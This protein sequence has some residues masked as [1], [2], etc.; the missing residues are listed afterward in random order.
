MEGAGLWHPPG[1]RENGTLSLG[2]ASFLTQCFLLSD[3]LGLLG[4][5]RQS[6]GPCEAPGATAGPDLPPPGLLPKV[7]AAPMRVPAGAAQPSLS[8]LVWT[9]DQLP[10][11]LHLG[12][13][14]DTFW[15]L[16]RWLPCQPSCTIL[17]FS[18]ILHG[19]EGFPPLL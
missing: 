12:G 18:H 3:L 6:V 14:L 4:E 19:Q 15:V 1:R 2:L 10:G 9:G 7:L 11:L 8:D 16:W 13:G 17:R 5:G